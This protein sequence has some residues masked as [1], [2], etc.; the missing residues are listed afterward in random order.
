[1]HRDPRPTK[2]T[3]APRGVTLLEL[4]VVSALLG[5]ATAVAVPNLMPTLARVRHHG[6]AASAASFV[7]AARRRAVA[8][9]RCYRVRKE[10]TALVAERRTSGD[11]VHLAS[12]TTAWA[13][14]ATLAAESGTSYVLAGQSLTVPA[15]LTAAQEDAHRVVFRP[16]GRLWGDGDLEVV[17]DGARVLIQSAHLPGES[18]AV[19]VTALGRICTQQEASTN[20]PMAQVGDAARC[21]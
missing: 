14:V 7:D 11:C 15:G 2:K 9:G 5:I 6:A 1:M 16:N 21:R 18:R 10:G 19:V 13:R 4:L 12:S 17:D 3:K 20:Q 8:E